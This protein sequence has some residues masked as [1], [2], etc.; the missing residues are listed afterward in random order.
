MIL[1]VAGV[2][3]AYDGKGRLVRRKGQLGV[4]SGCSNYPQCDYTVNFLV[5]TN[6]PK[7]PACGGFLTKRYMKKTKVPFWGC[8]N[9]PYCSYTAAVPAKGM[10]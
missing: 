6:T 1:N 10:V 4:F 5:S 3:K 7:C 9:Y 8:T 2:Y